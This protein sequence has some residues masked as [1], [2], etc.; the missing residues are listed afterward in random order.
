[1]PSSDLDL[2]S[3]ALVKLGAQPITSFDDL[4]A[5]AEVASRLYP[6]VRDALMSS[7][8]WCFTLAEAPLVLDPTPA[9]SEFSYAFFL[10][11]DLLRT[12]SAGVSGRSRGLLYRVQGGRLRANS[13]DVV[14]SYQRR[15]SVG[16]FP[17][18]FTAALVSRLAAEFCIPVTENTSRSEILH[19]LAAAEAQLAR[20][21][22]SQQNPPR[23]LDDYTLLSA[24]W[25]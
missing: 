2:C 16:E 9:Q 14:L 23:V 7:H 12:I 3:A 1:M 25:S 20:L 6:I 17:A 8:P 15:A 18:H 22:D 5:E 11:A 4:R 10:P 21:L 24:R 19:R 13:A